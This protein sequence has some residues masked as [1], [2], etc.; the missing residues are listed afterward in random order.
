LPKPPWPPPK[1]PP[2]ENPP[3]LGVF[4]VTWA[5]ARRRLGPTSSTS[6]SMTVRFSPSLVS[7]VRDFSR[8]WTTTRV[9]RCRDSATFSP[10]SRHTEQRRNRVSPSLN[11][12]AWRS[13]IRGVEAT[14]KFATA[15]PLGV[16]RSSG[17]LVRF[18][19]TVMTVSP[20][21]ECSLKRG[22]CSALLRVRAEDLRAQNGLVESELTIEFLGRCRLGVEIDHDVVA[23]GLLLDLVREATTSPDVH[24]V[25]GAVL[26]RDNLDQV[27]HGVSQRPLFEVVIKNEHELVLTHMSP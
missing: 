12:P 13:K 8:P 26:S 27:V 20:A 15:A 9:P 16:K 4:F 25:D 21:I 14:V 18:P 23:L 1:L 2:P 3:P 10:I 17:S 22:S 24:V 5:V 6:S 7:K 11:S 19:T